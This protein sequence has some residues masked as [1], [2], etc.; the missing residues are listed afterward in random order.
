MSSSVHF[1]HEVWL[2]AG[3]ARQRLRQHWL[4][5]LAQGRL[6]CQTALDLGRLVGETLAESAFW[7]RALGQALWRAWL[8]STAWHSARHWWTRHAETV[9][10]A[11]LGSV[12][13][14]LLALLAGLA[15][16]GQAM[17]LEQPPSGHARQPAFQA[18]L[19]FQPTPTLRA[20]VIPQEPE[21]DWVALPLPEPTATPFTLDYREWTSVLPAEG[22]WEGAGACPGSV[23]APLG[24]Q[25]WRWPADLRFLS[26]RNYSRS[27]PGLDF[28]ADY[29]SPIYASETGVVVYAGWNRHGYGNLVIV[30][31][32][33]GWHTLYAHLDQ[34]SVKCGQ[35]VAAGQALGL[36]GSTGN[37][38]GPH[39]HFE[40]RGPAGRV[41]PWDYLP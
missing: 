10:T 40:L 30:D 20:V 29:G 36:A 5:V 9:S 11:A 34:L 4:A 27:H 14:G 31:H 41:N 35:V 24:G 18:G 6:V 38:T 17:R 21:T 7:A 3:T 1:G 25:A 23:W 28:A 13:A 19:A 12:V 39:L 32:G 15:Q 37:S 2:A 22:G 8:N 33:A 26:G 16:T